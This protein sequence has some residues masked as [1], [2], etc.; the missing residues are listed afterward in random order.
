M[1][2]NNYGTQKIREQSGASVVSVETINRQTHHHIFRPPSFYLCVPFPK[3]E[4]IF[5]NCLIDARVKG[6][7]L[8]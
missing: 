3:D 5:F 7:G 1:D 2:T 8:V 4:F 6:G